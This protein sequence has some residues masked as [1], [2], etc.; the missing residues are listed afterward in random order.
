M[1][2]VRPTGPRTA[3]NGYVYLAQSVRCGWVKIGW[4]KNPAN[5]IVALAN[6]HRTEMALLGCVPG[7]G[8]DEQNLQ[9]RFRGS[10]VAYEWFG[11]TEEILAFA[12]SLPSPIKAAPFTPK[13]RSP[14]WL[15]ATVGGRWLEQRQPAGF[16]PPS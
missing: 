11:P 10:R 1:R 13:K 2:A 9:H 14:N 15:I 8:K 3:A 7:S 5:R 6:E 12:R 4:A 16:P